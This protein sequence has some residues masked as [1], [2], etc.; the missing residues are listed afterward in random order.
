MWVF[1]LPFMGARSPNMGFE[2]AKH[3]DGRHSWD[4]SEVD[5]RCA[6]ELTLF[7]SGG[8]CSDGCLYQWPM[9]RKFHEQQPTESALR[10]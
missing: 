6:D 3:G 9:L 10:R 2:V 8:Y 7:V 4:R 5:W 1:K